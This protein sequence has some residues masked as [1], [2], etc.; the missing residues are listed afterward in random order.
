M[1]SFEEVQYI[2][3]KD[4]SSFKCCFMSSVPCQHRLT[5]PLTS[6]PHTCLAICMSQD[7]TLGIL[8]LSYSLEGPNV[9]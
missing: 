7:R 6:H 2:N 3:L 4:C 8:N 9:A 5:T 1:H